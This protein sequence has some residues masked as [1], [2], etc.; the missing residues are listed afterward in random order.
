[1]G[2]NITK[3]K[4]AKGKN[5]KEENVKKRDKIRKMKGKWKVN[6]KYMKIKE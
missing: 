3:G 1:M 2:K 6:A 5:A 4:N